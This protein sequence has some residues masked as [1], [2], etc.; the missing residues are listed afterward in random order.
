MFYRNLHANHNFLT[1]VKGGILY[2]GIV[3]CPRVFLKHVVKMI[4]SV[5]FKRFY[6]LFN[7]LGLLL[8]PSLAQAILSFDDPIKCLA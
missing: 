6:T 5:A 4:N 7:R 1:F 3:Y 2:Q 8:L